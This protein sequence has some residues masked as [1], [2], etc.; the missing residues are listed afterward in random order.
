MKKP[1]TIQPE[2]EG[3]YKIKIDETTREGKV[4]LDLIYLLAEKQDGITIL[5]H[6]KENGEEKE[7]KK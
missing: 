4:F 6:E 7:A 1:V 5:S 3:F 2:E